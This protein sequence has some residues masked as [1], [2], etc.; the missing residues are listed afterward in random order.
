MKSSHLLAL[1]LLAPLSGC[2]DKSDELPKSALES[3]QAKASYS[4]GVDFATRLKQQSI[5]LETDAL[6]Q[7][8]KD[9]SSGAEP[10]LSEEEM[11]L[12]R[13]E[14]LQQLREEILAK[15]TAEGEKNLAAG[16]DFLAENA[17]K[18]GVVTTA[19]G[20]QYKIVE[21][22]TGATPTADDTV[23]THYRGTLIDGREFDSSY[24]RGTPATFPVKGVIKGWTEALQLMKV[25]AKWTLYVPSDLAYG[26]S[27]RSELIQP[28]AT[29]IF[30]IELLEIVKPE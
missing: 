14:F 23:V 6:V 13:T 19:S 20:L 11:N 16:A 2:F 7:G 28:N 9:G 18:E 5:T 21:A 22:G 1:A 12:A 3:V 15:D 17:S 10:K 24:T 30:D 29:L 26:P 8:I 25:G 4:F 27:K